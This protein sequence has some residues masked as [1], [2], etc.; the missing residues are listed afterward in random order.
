M[1]YKRLIIENKE[2]DQLKQII[3]AAQNK[4]D[5]TYKASIEKLIDELKHAQ[6]LN[7]GKMP[8]M[9]FGSILLSPFGIRKEI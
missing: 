1:K 8:V 6:F 5:L 9:W 2:Y 7:A 3:S 4:I